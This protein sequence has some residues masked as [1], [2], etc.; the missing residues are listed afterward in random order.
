MLKNDK[1]YPNQLMVNTHFIQ[2]LLS[3]LADSGYK[4]LSE[5]LAEAFVKI[6]ENKNT[7]DKKA[8]GKNEEN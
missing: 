5:L 1:I 3:D 8:G 7:K 4:N 6:P 2:A